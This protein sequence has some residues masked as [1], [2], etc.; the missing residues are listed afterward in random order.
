MK[1]K[2]NLTTYNGFQELLDIENYLGNYNDYIVNLF[3]NNFTS[4]KS[5]SNIIDF[6]SGIGT[7]SY[8]LKTK[9]NLSPICIEIDCQN[10]KVLSDRGFKYFN[11]LKQIKKKADFLF[12]SNVLEH[13]ENDELVLS[14][15]FSILKKGGYLFLYLP[16][17]DHLWTGLDDKVGHYRR[18]NKKQLLK[19]ITNCGFVIEKCHYADSIGYFLALLTKFMLPEPNKSIQPIILKIYNYIFLPFSKIFDSLGFKHIIGKNIVVLAK[20]I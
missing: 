16:A 12:S 18:Y 20:K 1:Q 10:K 14:E 3:L 4:I 2:N 7:L 19:K 8:I 11:N 9:T 15:I 13:I 17:H 5:D 6:G